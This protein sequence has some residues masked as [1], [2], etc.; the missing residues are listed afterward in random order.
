MRSSRSGLFISSTTKNQMVAAAVTF[1]VLLLFWII[2]WMADGAGPYLGQSM[3][4]VDHPALRRFRQR[5]DRHQAPRVLSELHRLRPVPDPEVGRHR[6]V[7]G[8]AVKRLLGLLGW[9][10]VLLVLA[11]VVLRFTQPE[12]AD[13][14]QRL[15]HGGPRGHGA[16]H[17]AASGATSRARSA[18]R[19]SST[20]RSR[21]ERAARSRRFSSAIN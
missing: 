7:E 16:L 17:P 14:Y 19:T 10:G 21:L 5:R 3:L 8:L 4:P 20:D 15:A 11:A 1:V 12:L 13:W 18:A 2:N 9:L 6:T